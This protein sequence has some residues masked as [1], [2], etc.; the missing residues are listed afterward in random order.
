ML[1]RQIY[2]AGKSKSYLGLNVKCPT[3]FFDSNQIWIFSTDFHAS[4]HYLISRK[5]IQ[6]KP[7]WHMRTDGH[8][9]DK[10]RHPRL[11]EHV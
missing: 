11:C 10:G 4:P 1:L 9:E 8:D 2:D 7:R 3:V 5:S 6:W